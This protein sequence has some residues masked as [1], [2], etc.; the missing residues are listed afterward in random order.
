VQER[1][2]EQRSDHHREQERREGQEEIGDPHQRFAEQPAAEP[3][4]EADRNSDQDG[5]C[6]DRR[7]RTERG[8][9]AEQHPGEEIASQ[10]IGTEEVR[11]AG[12]QLA[13]T[14]VGCAAALRRVRCEQRG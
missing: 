1:R 8:A 7:G 3:G 12:R 13:C 5:E 4:D 9:R 10:V 2:S 11:P 6:H 14:D